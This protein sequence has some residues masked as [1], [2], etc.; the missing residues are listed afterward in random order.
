MEGNAQIFSMGMNAPVLLVIRA[1]NARII[2]AVA[3]LV[4]AKIVENVRRNSGSV[5]TLASATNSGQDRTVPR[6]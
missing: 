5:T 3:V 2:L 4:H 6:M 1:V